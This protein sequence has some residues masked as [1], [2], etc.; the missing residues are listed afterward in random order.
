MKKLI[1]LLIIGL[2]FIN[3]SFSQNYNRNNGRG[4]IPQSVIYHNK[5]QKSL[6]FKGFSNKNKF[7]QRKK[8]SKKKY[9]FKVR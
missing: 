7:F 3:K 1:L 4:I 9:N 6:M 2:I 8:R 5:L